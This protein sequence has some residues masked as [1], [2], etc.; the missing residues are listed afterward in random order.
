MNSERFERGCE[1]VWQLDG[2]RLD[3][4][5]GNKIPNADEMDSLG[6]YVHE[7]AYGDIYNRGGIP[8]RERLII[9]IVVTAVLGGCDS[10]LKGHMERAVKNGM[11]KK[12]LEEMI[13]QISVYAGFPR[14]IIA[15]RIL[16]EI[17]EHVSEKEFQ[18]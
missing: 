5:E 2:H 17:S 13:I 6:I 16:S 7:Y 4:S 11:T 15:N 18:Q 9:N 8:M 1:M 12:E 14:A 3:G 10:L